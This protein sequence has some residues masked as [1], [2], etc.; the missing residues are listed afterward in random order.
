V[1]EEEVR[2]LGH[3]ERVD[4]VEEKLD[5]GDPAGGGGTAERGAHGGSK[6]MSVKDS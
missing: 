3:R 2:E 1:V 5:V 6:G 4:E